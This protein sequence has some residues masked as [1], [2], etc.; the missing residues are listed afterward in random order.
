MAEDMA[1]THEKYYGKAGKGV[2]FQ[3][4]TTKRGKMPVGAA[5]VDDVIRS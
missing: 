2:I 4:Q 3:A 5:M 1:L